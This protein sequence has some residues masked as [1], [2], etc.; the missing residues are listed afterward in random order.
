MWLSEKLKEGQRPGGASADLGVTTIGGE[1]AGVY[2][3]GELRE[4]RICTPGGVCWQPRSGDKVVVLKGGNDGEEVFV[5]GV[6]GKN[7]A[8]IAAGEL[9]FRSGGASICLRNNGVI[10]LSGELM[11]NGKPYAPCSCGL[12]GETTS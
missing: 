1:K 5:L 12:G 10:E 4:V 3:R 8:Q 6:E 2:S 9:L 7:E 11:I